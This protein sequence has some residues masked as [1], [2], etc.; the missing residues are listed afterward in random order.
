MKKTQLSGV[1]P[2]GTESMTKTIVDLFE[3]QAYAHPKNNAL[4]FLNGQMNYDD[5]NRK[6]NQLAHHLIKCGVVKECL[7]AV[8]IERSA[9]MVIAILAILKAGAAYVPIEPD[10][11]VERIQFMLKD[12]NALFA[13]ASNQTKDRLISEASLT[14]IVQDNDGGLSNELT[15]NVKHPAAE[16]LAYVMYTSGSTGTPKG[17]MVEHGNI[18]ALVDWATQEFSTEYF[19]VVYASTSICFDLSVFEIFFP[20]SAGKPLR[21]VESGLYIGAYLEK[22]TGV[23]LNTVPGVVESLLKQGTDLSGITMLNMAG[24]PIPFHILQKLDNKN[25]EARNLYGP[26]ETT[27]YS[28]VF[29]LPK[30]QPALIGRPIANTFIYILNPLGEKTDVG[31][32]GEIYI[33]G[34][35]VARGYLNNDELTTQRF[36]QDPFQPYEGCRMY[37]TGDLGRWKVDGNIEY[38]GRMD[39]QV[40]IRGYRIELT[41]IENVLEQSPLVQRAIVTARH[42]RNGN[43]RL[44]AYIIPEKKF[45]KD[46]IAAWLRE[47]LPEFMVPALLV[48]IDHIPVS[49]NGKTD[50]KALPDPDENDFVRHEYLPPVTVAE[51]QMAAIWR[52][53]LKIDPIST[54]DNFFELGGNSLMTLEVVSRAHDLG[55]LLQP[56]DIYSEPTVAGLSAVMATKKQQTS[57]DDQ[58]YKSRKAPSIVCIQKEGERPP[59]FA[60]PGFWLYQKLALH[61]GNSQPF[62]GFEPYPYRD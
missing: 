43:K 54:N 28:T 61:L 59:F 15:T 40:K 31:R 47:K 19:S 56:M 11:P 33:G 24:E 41:E 62:Y 37:K 57:G 60:I 23:L 22:D 38:I 51:K 48:E 17:V 14:I 58:Q 55:Y 36:M 5:L 50:R 44:V 3:E 27:V 8:C 46:S 21:I 9:E 52:T 1:P 6:S 20:L 42:G 35:G 7:V 25:L 49:I 39:D 18:A 32:T 10:Y 16:D 2:G 12:S 29:I 26:T 34:A 53:I 45:K 13:I 4:L 30:G